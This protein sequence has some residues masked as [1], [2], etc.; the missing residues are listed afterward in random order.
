MPEVVKCVANVQCAGNCDHVQCDVGQAQRL[1]NLK[2]Q[3]GRRTSPAEKTSNSNS[4]KCPQC[5]F[6]TKGKSEL[7]EHVRREHSKYPSCPFCL[8][9]FYNRLALNQH[10]EN[11]HSENTQIV[12]EKKTGEKRNLYLLSSAQGMQEGT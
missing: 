8:I 6:T 10:I 4:F 12:R 7:E 2:N 9:G 1:I 3:G 5:N 11:Y